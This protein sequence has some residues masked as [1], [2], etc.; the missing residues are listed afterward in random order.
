MQADID[1]LVVREGVGARRLSVSG[2][3]LRR[4]PRLT[5]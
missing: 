1:H 4:N 2:S 5:A 3:E